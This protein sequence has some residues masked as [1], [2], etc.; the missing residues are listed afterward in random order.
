[1]GR[2]PELDVKRFEQFF[3]NRIPPRVRDQVAIEVTTRGSSVTLWE[4]RPP[5]NKDTGAEWTRTEIAQLRYSGEHL[6]WTLF[7]ADQHGKWRPYP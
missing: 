2:L 1:M 4:C 6:T 3:A 5:W 7:W